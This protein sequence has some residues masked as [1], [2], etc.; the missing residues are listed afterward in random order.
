[1]VI[2]K[3]KDIIL[4]PITLGDA[5]S[6]YEVHQNKEAKKNFV[7]IPKDVKE[8]RK[9]LQVNIKE[10]RKSKPSSE[11]FAI[12]FKEEFAGFVIIYSLNKKPLQE[13]GSIGVMA[14]GIHPK[15][16]GKGLATKSLK[17]LTNYS[18]K[19]FK[20]KRIT[21]RCR[22]FNKASCRVLEKAGYKFEG[23]HRKEVYSA[24]KYYDNAYWAKVK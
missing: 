14:F 4:R 23:I 9:E 11:S 16:K 8:A 12:I 2:L 15:L 6:Y 18:F 7:G 19:K 22:N 24:G 21:G 17:L 10:M 5:K 13:N 3:S 1:M 20:L